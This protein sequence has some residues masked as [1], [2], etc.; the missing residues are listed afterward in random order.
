MK[1]PIICLDFDGVVHSYTSGWRGARNIPDPP[2]AGAIEF[3]LEALRHYDVVIHS[4]RARY[5]GGISAMRRWLRFHAGNLW[6]DT[7]AGPGIEDVRFTRWKPSAVVTID[8][9]AIRFEGVFPS[10]KQA[11]EM[12]AWN[13]EGK[14][15]AALLNDATMAEH[16]SHIDFENELY[17]TLVDPVAEGPIKED[18]MRRQLLE[19]ARWYRQHC[20][21]L[22]NQLNVKMKR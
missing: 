21:D 6:W 1:R 14:G 18:V 19:S 8:D 11:A 15:L 7:P 20:Q 3:I 12:K 22:E 9:R 16:R 13:R 10:P 4:S 5:W 2:V 17:A